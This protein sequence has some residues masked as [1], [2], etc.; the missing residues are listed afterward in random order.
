MNRQQFCWYLLFI[1]HKQPWMLHAEVSDLLTKILSSVQSQWRWIQGHILLFQS[2]PSRASQF[3]FAVVF[4]FWMEHSRQGIGVVPCLSSEKWRLGPNPENRSRVRLTNTRHSAMSIV[5]YHSEQILNQ[6]EWR[7]QYC[8]SGFVCYT[9]SC[10]WFKSANFALHSQYKGPQSV[11][12]LM[13]N[14]NIIQ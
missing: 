8:Y 11:T 13:P 12:A 9:I 1:S 14:Y 4:S 10:L 2:N 6:S 3:S 7:P 5:A